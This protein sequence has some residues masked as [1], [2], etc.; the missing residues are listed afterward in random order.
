MLLVAFLMCSVGFDLVV[1]FGV[2]LPRNVFAGSVEKPFD[3][4]RTDTSP[5]ETGDS[6]Q[7]L[8]V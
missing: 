1:G 8:G 7:S 5:T 2:T 4:L 6:L 3:R